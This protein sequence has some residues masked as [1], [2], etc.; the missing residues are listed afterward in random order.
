MLTFSK[1]AIA[2]GILL[3][4]VGTSQAA[5]VTIPQELADFPSSFK[6]QTTCLQGVT[7]LSAHY[8]TITNLAP[9]GWRNLIIFGGVSFPWE[10]IA[11]ET[12]PLLTQE[13]TFENIGVRRETLNDMSRILWKSTKHSQDAGQVIL[14]ELDQK[15]YTH[16]KEFE[17]DPEHDFD[18]TEQTLNGTGGQDIGWYSYPSIWKIVGFEM[19][20]D[21]NPV[22]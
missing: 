15:C 3:S 1:F 20:Y 8:T 10:V 18:I 14:T 7:L 12:W 22:H 2:A 16:F 11:M 21:G 17:R 19:D 6:N 9:E 5:K 4:A 13:S